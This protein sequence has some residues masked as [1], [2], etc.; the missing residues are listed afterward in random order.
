MREGEFDPRKFGSFGELPEEQK[1][2]F[3]PVE[4]GG[5][6][7]KEAAEELKLAEKEAEDENSNRPRYKKIL[8]VGKVT[9][10]DMEHAEAG[11]EDYVE[12]ARL[13]TKEYKENLPSELKE[14]LAS[15]VFKGR[16]K[17]Y[18]EETE[19]YINVKDIEAHG[20]DEAIRLAFLEGDENETLRDIS[21][22]LIYKDNDTVAIVKNGQTFRDREKNVV[23][24]TVEV[25]HKGKKYNW[26]EERPDII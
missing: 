9:G 23:K 21:F 6:V 19:T 3:V 7:R 14:K 16:K 8:G 13:K 24:P 5:F 2:N 22:R 15:A 17:T 18:D 11:D 12:E 20:L 1:A 10:V 4:G 26:L 25:K